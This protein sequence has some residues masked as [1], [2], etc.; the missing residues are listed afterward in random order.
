MMVYPFNTIRRK[1]QRNL[2][3]MLKV[4]VMSILNANL[5][6]MMPAPLSI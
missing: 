3:D 6:Q 1:S 4:T 2:P 5:E